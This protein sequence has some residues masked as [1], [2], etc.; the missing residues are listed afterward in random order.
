MSAW[1]SLPEISKRW[2]AVRSCTAPEVRAL[3]WS[4]MAELEDVTLDG[5]PLHSLRVADLKAALEQRGL[6]KSGQKNALIK[7]L[8]GVSLVKGR[9]FNTVRLLSSWAEDERRQ[10]GQVSVHRERECL[11]S[12]YWRV[13]IV[14][15][16]AQQLFSIFY[17][18]E[19]RNLNDTF[20]R[21][22]SKQSGSWQAEVS[23]LTSCPRV[24][25]L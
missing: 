18:V 13:S 10:A 14:F 2:R 11:S 23:E 15:R 5:K 21:V 6:A 25:C 22:F 17:A 16:F 1:L 3:G 4:K 9:A 8:K 7:R 12:A 24:V 20:I 19:I